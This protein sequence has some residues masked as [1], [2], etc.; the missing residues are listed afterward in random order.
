MEPFDTKLTILVVRI[1]IN[2]NVLFLSLNP[3]TLSLSSTKK[4]TKKE[5][6]K[7]WYQNVM[8]INYMDRL[9]NRLKG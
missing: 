5:K 9:P 6:N 3:T 1:V 2:D 8:F 4:R 7:V